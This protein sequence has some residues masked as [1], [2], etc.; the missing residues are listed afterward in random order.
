MPVLVLPTPIRPYVNGQREVPVNGKNVAEAMESLLVQ[1]PALRPHLTN[2]RG[3][4]RSFVNL[5][6]G[7]NNIRD[8]QGLETLLNEGDRLMLIPSIAGG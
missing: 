8:L 1:Y 6:I 7:E 5:F 2:S 4:F 3:E